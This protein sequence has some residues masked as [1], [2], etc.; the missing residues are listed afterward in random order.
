MKWVSGV[1]LPS[2]QGLLGEILDIQVE[3]A[4]SSMHQHM[5]GLYGTGQCNGWKN[6]AKSSLITSMVNTEYNISIC[7]LVSV[8]FMKLT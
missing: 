7:Q 4:Y 8:I 5:S 1:T 2:Q 6:I 3:K